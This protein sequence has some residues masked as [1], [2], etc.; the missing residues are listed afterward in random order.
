MRGLLHEDTAK[1]GGIRRM[2][3]GKYLYKKADAFTSGLSLGNPAACIYTG[4]DTLSEQEM[5]CIARQHKGFVSEVVYCADS[6]LSDCKLTYYSSEC[7][8]DF[9]G[10]GTI[11]AMYELLRSNEALRRKKE[12]SFETNR[13][14][15][16][17][18]YNEMDKED[19]VYITAPEARR[20][21]VPATLPTI[22][23][24]L[25]VEGSVLS[26][27]YPLALI[28]AGLRTL[29]VPIASLQSEIGIFP[30]EEQLK[31]FCRDH[32][33]DIILI[34]C[35]ET[36]CP[37]FIAHTRVFAPKFGYLE[38]PATGSG[39]SAFGYY[40]HDNQ[41]W[42]GAP[43]VIEQGGKD[44]LFN[45]IKLKMKDNKILFGG[46]AT[47]RIDGYYIL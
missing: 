5:L 15:T 4:R 3:E 17:F 44:N 21:E 38:D 8:V 37:G 11:A 40:L 47:L 25:G 6:D 20:Y 34:F 30:C 23:H 27:D 22:S 2:K 16:L 12:I 7:E 42:D 28:D 13:K 36:D 1:G 39:N 41:L 31:L 9:C 10:H 46:R 24:A 29:I 26:N 43:A 14:G 45:S 35:L 18:L 32:G 19:A 33:I